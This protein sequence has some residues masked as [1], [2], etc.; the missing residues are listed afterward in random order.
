MPAWLTYSLLAILFWGA[1]GLESK[2]LV[3]K[4]SP[5][6][7]QVLFTLGLFLPAALVL[8]SR[9]R[10]AGSNRRRGLFFAVLTGLLGGLGNI[11]FYMALVPGKASVVVP[12]TSLSPLV[13]VLLA[14]VA[15]KEKVNRRQWAGVALAL[16]AIYLLSL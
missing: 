4:T 14:V 15:M 13:T 12:I 6:T 1:W 16:T 11:A 8:C 9:R 5:Y 7:G 2:L 10:F 3:D